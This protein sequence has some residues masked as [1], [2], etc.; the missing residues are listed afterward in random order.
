[1][2]SEC[3]GGVIYHK[4]GLKFLSPTINLW[5]K[6]SDFLKFLN[7]LEYYLNSAPLIEEKN[8]KLDYPVG[9]LG[10]KK[11]KIKLYFLHY[12]SFQDAMIKWNKRKKRVNLSNL[13]VI[14]TDRDG[15]DIEMLKKFDRLP[16]ENKVILTGKAYPEI[17]SALLLDNCVE[18]GHLGDLFKTNFF[19][20]KSK[21]DDFDFVEFLNGNGNKLSD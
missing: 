11:M 4:L 19:T 21:L 5:F 17:K 15:A 1:M 7:N 18:D 3:A 14:M 20:G 8:S 10:D 13:F 6:P 16:F 2:A 9:I 12:T